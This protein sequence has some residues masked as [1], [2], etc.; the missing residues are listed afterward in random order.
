MMPRDALASQAYDTNDCES[1][2]TEATSPTKIRN[3][4][5]GLIKAHGPDHPR[6][7]EVRAELAV[8]VTSAAIQKHLSRAPALSEAQK[9]KLRSLI[10]TIGRTPQ[11]A[12]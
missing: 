9:A 2:R 8:A 5:G 6:V 11:E 10:S 4:L 7:A 12:A 3:E 1:F